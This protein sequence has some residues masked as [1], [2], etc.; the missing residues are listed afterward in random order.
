MGLTLFLL[1]LLDAYHPPAAATALVITSGISRPGPPLYGMLTGLA[2]V[3]TI[4]P[5]LSLGAGGGAK[6]TE[7]SR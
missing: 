6:K 3:L 4:A 1:H 5:V 2:L 7:H